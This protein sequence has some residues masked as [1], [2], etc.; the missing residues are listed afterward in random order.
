MKFT[1]KDL[2]FSIFTGG[3][4]GLIVWRI[5]NFLGFRSFPFAW[6][7]LIVPIIWILGV[8]LGYF[9][10]R[11]FN[12]FNQF[13]KF[14]AIGFTNAAVDFGILNFLI[15][16]SSITV[17]IYYSIFKAVSFFMAMVNSY[18]LN[19]HWAFNA[20][21]DGARGVE[22]IKFAG[23]AIAAAL[24]NVGVASYVVNSIDPRFG[25]SPVVWANVAAILGSA[26]A[27]VFS[28]A[29]FKILVFKERT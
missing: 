8:H 14:A 19:K 6:L 23:V 21:N 9:L 18:F 4:T 5:F 25:F 11:W 27:L 22:F 2:W 29:G 20:G 13:G 17:G 10:G 1:K 12:F 24:I 16:Y 26:S 7:I 3:G 15:A 28:F